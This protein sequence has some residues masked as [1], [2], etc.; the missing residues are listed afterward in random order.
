MSEIERGAARLTGLIEQW[1]RAAC[2]FCRR[3]NLICAADM[4]AERAALHCPTCGDPTSLCR[5]RAATTI[6]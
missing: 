5:C 6:A 4:C 2:P 1:R 3:P